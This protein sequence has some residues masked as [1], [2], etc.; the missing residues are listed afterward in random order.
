MYAVD[1]LSD[2]IDVTR[3][4]LTPIRP[5]TWLKLAIVV[6]FVGGPGLSTPTTPTGDVG[7]TVDGPTPDAVEPALPTGDVLAFV[8]VIA[9][10]AI[11]IWLV[12]ALVGS[13]MEFVFIESLRASTVHVRRYASANLGH[14]VQLFLF[15]VVATLVVFVLVGVPALAVIL[16]AESLGSVSIG[17]LLLIALAAIPLSI[18]YAIVTSF[19]TVFVAPVMLLEDRGIVAAWRRFWPT[20]TANWKE[21][22]V[23][24]VLAWI[25]QFALGFAVAFLAAFGGIALAIP[26]GILIV[27]LLALGPV[28]VALAVGVG[29]VALVVFLFLVALLQ[30][31]VYSYLRYYALLLLGDTNEELDLIPDQRAAVRSDGGEWDEQSDDEWG[32]SDERD[33]QSDDDRNGWE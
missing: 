18:A 6:F 19:T 24:L 4:F 31:P 28:G 25:V 16:S 22:G 23:Y 27:V 14:A 30:V 11:T 17:L 26:F 10:V 5:G 33:D 20:F 8:A 29:L 15:R 1:D 21:Y 13:I 7:P 2:A 3:E 32:E 9:A 12:F